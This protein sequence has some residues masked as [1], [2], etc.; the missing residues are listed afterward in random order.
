MNAV[1]VLKNLADETRLHIMLLLTHEDELCVC[2][3]VAALD[4]LQPK[5]SRHLRLLKD[6]GLIQDRRQGQWMYYAWADDLPTWVR[7]LL[8]GLREEQAKT[9]APCLVNLSTMPDRPT[10]C[11]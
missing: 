1:S 9:L 3:L 5:I 11:C 4:Q 8:M 10:R 2:E 6:A 7:E